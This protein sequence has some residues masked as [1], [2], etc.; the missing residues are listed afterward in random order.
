MSNQINVTNKRK[1]WKEW[2]NSRKS[3]ETINKK[4]QEKL[5]KNF[6]NTKS[7]DQ[8]KI[9]LENYDETTFLFRQNFGTN[10]VGI[11][12]HMKSVGKTIYTEEDEEF[13][14]IQG[15]E[16]SATYFMTP[17]SMFS[18]DY[19]KMMQYRYQQQNNFL[20]LHQ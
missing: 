2:F 4:G 1:A 13:G 16:K 11:F 19:L 20:Q 7:V 12:H 18:L 3:A 14:F 10:T 5:F 9:D 6:E 17:D 8:C 15:V